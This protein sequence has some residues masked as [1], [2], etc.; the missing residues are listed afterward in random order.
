M[1]NSAHAGEFNSPNVLLA[2]G[3]LQMVSI[4]T[5][6][7]TEWQRTRTSRK[8]LRPTAQSNPLHKNS[9][10]INKMWTKNHLFL[11]LLLCYYW[12]ICQTI[13]TDWQ[14]ASQNFFAVQTLK[15]MEA[16]GEKGKFWDTTLVRFPEDTV[17][18]L[19]FLEV[20]YGWKHKLLEI[21][22][23]VPLTNDCK[24]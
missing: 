22:S 6:W 10:I 3:C 4:K 24:Y 18:K 19:L 13:L 16:E 2:F 1:S 21:T 23:T 7:Q 14:S 5:L 17:C 9:Q 20:L 11:L 12:W 15:M 8:H